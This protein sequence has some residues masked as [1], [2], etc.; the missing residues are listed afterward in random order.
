MISQGDSI[1]TSYVAFN[2]ASRISTRS[3]GRGRE[4]AVSDRFGNIVKSLN[5]IPSGEG[6]VAFIDGITMHVGERCDV[7]WF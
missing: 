7:G 3:G 5:F 4:A 1:G 6:H 2:T